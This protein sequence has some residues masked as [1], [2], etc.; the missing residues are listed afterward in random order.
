M[1]GDETLYTSGKIA[2][3]KRYIRDRPDIRDH[4]ASC[5]H[6]SKYIN[7]VAIMYDGRTAQQRD[8]PTAAAAHGDHVY[9]HAVHLSLLWILSEIPLTRG[10][11][12]ASRR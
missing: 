3:R 11:D 9:P 2:A 8:P 10:Q 7:V 5:T 1:D 6:R 4:V 12:C